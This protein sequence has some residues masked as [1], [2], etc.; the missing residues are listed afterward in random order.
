[1]TSFPLEFGRFPRSVTSV[2]FEDRESVERERKRERE[3]KGER[4]GGRESCQRDLEKRGRFVSQRE[5]EDIKAQGGK[6]AF[7]FAR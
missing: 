3:K 5:E 7:L 1:M 2:R 4:E 6:S